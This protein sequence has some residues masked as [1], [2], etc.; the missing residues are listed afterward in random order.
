ME[1]TCV[2]NSR[3]YFNATSLNARYTHFAMAPCEWYNDKTI[4]HP[5]LMLVKK[6]ADTIIL[7]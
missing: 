7:Y 1:Y 6:K 2:A 5:Y 3:A 4:E